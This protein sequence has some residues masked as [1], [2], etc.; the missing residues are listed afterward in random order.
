MA[1]YL[2]HE[3]IHFLRLAGL[4][5]KIAPR[6]VRRSF[7]YEIHPGQLEQFL[8]KNRRKIDDLYKKRVITLAQYDLLYPKGNATHF[9]LCT[10]ISPKTNILD[11]INKYRVK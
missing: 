2:A 3:D 6:A 10:H 5:I 1:T 8:S 7:D 9:S 11:N 4:L